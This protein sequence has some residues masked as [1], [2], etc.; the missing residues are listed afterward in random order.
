MAARQ[1][2]HPVDDL[3]V[4][5]PE[6][7]DELLDLQR[8]ITDRDLVRQLLAHH[9]DGALIGIGH[10]GHIGVAVPNDVMQRLQIGLRLPARDDRVTGAA[11][12]ELVVQ[13]GCERVHDSQ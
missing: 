12:E 8:E 13:E 11:C 5:I 2:L 3:G 9:R 6:M 1:G 10:G 4:G 7:L